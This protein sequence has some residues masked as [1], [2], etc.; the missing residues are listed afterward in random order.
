MNEMRYFVCCPICGSRMMRCRV[1][2]VEIKCK[3]CKGLWNVFLMDEE[4][5]IRGAE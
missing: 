1:A 4:L 3:K 2:E 5:V